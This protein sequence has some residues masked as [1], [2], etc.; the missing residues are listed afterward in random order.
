MKHGKMFILTM[1]KLPCYKNKS[2]WCPGT[3]I[4]VPMEPKNPWTGKYGLVCMGDF[5]G[6]MEVIYLLHGNVTMVHQNV[7]RNRE[8]LATVHGKFIL[9]HGKQRISNPCRQGQ[10]KFGI[11]C[12]FRPEVVFIV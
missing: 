4:P 6:N 3:S 7:C 8:K 1:E 10:I 9:L 11:F 12:T 5:R 2:S